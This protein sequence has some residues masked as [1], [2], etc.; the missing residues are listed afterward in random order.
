MCHMKIVRNIFLSLT[1]LVSP[2]FV[3]VGGGEDGNKEVITQENSFISW[4]GSG[5]YK[6]A[7][8]P[9]IS[10]GSVIGFAADKTYFISMVGKIA[11]FG[12]LK[13]N[14]VG[15]FINKHE[16]CIGSI[17]FS[18]VAVP[19]VYLAWNKYQEWEKQH[20]QDQD[21][22]EDFDDIRAWFNED[23]DKDDESETE[24]VVGN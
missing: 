5:A 24:E 8:F 12:F 6:V 22:D 14:F 4:M 9:V 3:L 15:K 13:E 21:E 2:A 10:A 23:D 1:L 7:S 16:G 20:D 17:V 18:A 11:N 19:I